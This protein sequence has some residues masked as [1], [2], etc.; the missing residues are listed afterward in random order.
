MTVRLRYAF[1]IAYYYLTPTRIRTWLRVGQSATTIQ[2]VLKLMA[3][4]TTT[5][6]SL[7]DISKHIDWA[8]QEF[9]DRT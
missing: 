9:G 2:D 4:D 7:V 1:I 3:H 6:P 5:W 8:K